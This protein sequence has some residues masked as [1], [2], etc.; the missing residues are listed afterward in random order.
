[1]EQP[2]TTGNSLW[3]GLILLTS[4]IVFLVVLVV[5]VF[6]ELKR[7][8]DRAIFKPTRTHIAKPSEPYE[9]LMIN[10]RVSAW[11]LDRGSDEVLMFLHGNSS[12]I[13]HRTY[14]IEFSRLAGLSLL[15]V[16]YRGYGKSTGVPSLSNMREDAL[17]SFDYLTTRYSPENIILWS[18]SLG[19]VAA[20]YLVSK[21]RAKVLC[22]MAGVSSFAT[23][24]DTHSL[25]SDSSLLETL[26]NWVLQGLDDPPNYELFE[27]TL[28]P[29]FFVH[30]E[31]DEL[32]P[33]VCAEENV[34]Y[35]P[36]DKLVMPLLA[37]K[38]GHA[39][40]EITNRDLEKLLE[41]IGVE[42]DVSLFVEWLKDVSMVGVSTD[43]YLVDL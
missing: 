35:C 36:P 28:T 32:V 1:M 12:N 13:S 29:V 19:S 37:I 30:S 2:L 34:T 42:R 22:V 18:E 31:T 40:P 26:G 15:L 23:I 41:A 27:R 33:Y 39:T 20:A 8:R 43:F 21:R 4:I 3:G 38:G 10:G 6:A 9:E 25:T 16:D 7:V 11:L 5:L 24:F 17:D 14:M